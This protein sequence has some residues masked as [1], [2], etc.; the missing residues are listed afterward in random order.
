MA[1]TRKSME[2]KTLNF[3]DDVRTFNKG[4]VELATVGTVTFGRA[5]LEPGGNGLSP[6]S[7]L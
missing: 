2:K 4:R 3:P 6:L 7:R 1:K 5:N